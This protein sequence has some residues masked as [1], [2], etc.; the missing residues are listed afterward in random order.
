MNKFSNKNSL[1]EKQLKQLNK[2]EEKL[3]AEKNPGVIKTKLSPLKAKIEEKIPEKLQATLNITFEKG[4]KTVFD[5]GIGIIEKTYNKENINME[6]DINTYAINKYPNKKNL[7]KID[8]SASKKT[9]INKSVSAIEGGTLGLLG[10]GLPDMPIYIGVIL[11]SIYE[12]SLSYGFDYNSPEER[13][14]ILNIICASVTLGAERK[15]YFNKLDT[16]ASEIDN[17]QYHDY[18]IDEI[19]KETSNKISTYMLT[20]K[21]IQGLPI[22]G[23]IGGITNFKTLQDISTIAKL[24]YKQRYLNKLLV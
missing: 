4:F 19:L 22:V 6:F 21:F 5:K 24:K 20:S 7:K 10:I 17:N 23:V 9:F 8:K 18:N 11:K 14:Y 15:I 2:K 3:L 1:I 16:I 13:V 12:I